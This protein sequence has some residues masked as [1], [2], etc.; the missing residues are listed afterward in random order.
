MNTSIDVSYVGNFARKMNRL[1][2]AN[3]AQLSGGGITFPFPN[4]NTGGNH[5]FLELA[6]NDGSS[7]YNALSW[8]YTAVHEGT[9]VWRELYVEPQHRGFRRQ[10]DGRSISAEYV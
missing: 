10:L 6:T 7:D 4:L 9:C 5:A 1:Q 2:N 8:P 3:Q